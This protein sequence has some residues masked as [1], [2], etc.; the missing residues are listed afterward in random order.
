MQRQS[1]TYESEP[2]IAQS[3]INALDIEVMENRENELVFS[4]SITDYV[5][6]YNNYF[7]IDHD[8]SYLTPA[9]EWQQYIYDSSI[10][11]DHKT[12]CYYFTEDEQVYSVPTITVYV[13][14]NRDYIQEITV[15][16][17]EH[18]YTEL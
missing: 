2:T 5:E 10:H 16:F 9:Y 3:E 12:K 11:S 1:L 8:R 14:T 13:P 15:N 6:S 7:E 17:D 4:I 18:S